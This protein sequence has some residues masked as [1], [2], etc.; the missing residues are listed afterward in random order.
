LKQLPGS[1]AREVITRVKQR[2]EELK[3]STFLPGVNYEASYDVSRFLDASFHE[4]MRTLFEAFIL[5]TLVVYL[6]LQDWRSTL[7]PALVVPVSL[8][9]TFAFI[10]AAGFTLN[11]VTLFALLL[12]IGIVVDN[13]IVVVEAVHAKMSQGI[14]ARKATEAAMHEISGAILAITLVMAAVFVPV[15]FMTGPTGIFFRQFSI[16]MAIAITLSGV[17]ALTLTP[18]LCALMLKNEHGKK[19]KTNRVS[20][21]L[22]G[23]NK[24]YDGLS[25]RYQKLLSKIANRRTATFGM[26]LAFCIFSGL[27]GKL[28]PSGFIPDEDQGTFFISVTSPSGA[29]MER[30]EAVIEDIVRSVKSID[31]I[32]SVSTADGTNILSDGTGAT[33]GTCLVNLKNWKDR[34]MSVQEVMD[35]VKEKTG[36]IKDA[37]L[38]IFLPPP[39]P[40][41]GNAGG[42]EVKV[43]DKTGRNDLNEMQ[44]VSDD[45]IAALKKRKEIG[46]AFTIYDATFPQ[47]TLH[48]DYDKAAQ[49]GVTAE[50][51]MGELSTLVGSEYASN[52]VRFGRTYK[53]MVQALPQYR[54]RP[55]DIL[56]LTVKNDSDQMVPLS[57]FMTMDKTFGV[58]QITRYN[59]YNSAEMNGEEATGFSSGD[60]IR[61]CPGNR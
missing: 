58:D 57:A 35:L 10:Q 42:F 60:A 9:G 36:H 55:E 43:I 21:F 51:A 41:Y 56:K 37:R 23:F 40:G 12:A 11:L 19:K 25:E 17:S 15:A 5:V 28:V 59:M 61:A 48:V 4:V 52:F 34:K 53:V 16:T 14:G 31:A 27:L 26:L 45:F 7:I 13:A 44:K 8:I 39:I 2:M 46:S 24:W 38:D 29:T 54:A 33:Y 50:K 30:T 18:A 20:R 49:K 3:K 1:N 47:Y 6:F 22:D 32:E